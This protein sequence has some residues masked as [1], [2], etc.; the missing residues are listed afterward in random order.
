VRFEP[1][2]AA[3]PPQRSPLRDELEQARDLDRCVEVVRR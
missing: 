3:G 1:D 2:R